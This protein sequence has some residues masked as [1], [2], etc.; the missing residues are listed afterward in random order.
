MHLPQDHEDFQKIVEIHASLTDP[1]LLPPYDLALLLFCQCN[2]NLR[3]VIV[4]HLV[5]LY[6]HWIRVLSSEVRLEAVQDMMESAA[7]R[8][9]YVLRV[10]L[11]RLA[12]E[13]DMW[14]EV[15]R[16]FLLLGTVWLATASYQ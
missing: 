2:P 7:K 8:G 11:Q 6:S 16:F 14:R 13:G 15:I 9:M 10:V 1:F 3:Q 4:T 12:N 5:W